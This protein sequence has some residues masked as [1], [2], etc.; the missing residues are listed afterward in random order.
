MNVPHE[1]R[2]PS[3]SNDAIDA[4]IS[5]RRSLSITVFVITLF[6]MAPAMRT[7]CADPASMQTC[8]AEND[9]SIAACTRIIEDK[10][11]SAD[12][13]TAAY[14]LRGLGYEKTGD[15]KRAIADYDQAIGLNSNNATAY[16]GRGIVYSNM[17]Q[18]DQALVEYNHALQLNPKDADS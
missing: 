17:G 4:W 15:H 13:R 12:D 1:T 9:Q 6:V 7:A 16:L 18:Y 2:P 5:N 3:R 8:L 14:D 11:A 10:T